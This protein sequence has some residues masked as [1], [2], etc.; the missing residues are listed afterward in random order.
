MPSGAL[1]LTECA[2]TL[3][4][5]PRW[6]HCLTSPHSPT[7]RQVTRASVLSGRP[8]NTDHVLD[9]PRT[10]DHSSHGVREDP[11][12][13]KR[14][15]QRARQAMDRCVAEEHTTDEEDWES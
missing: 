7:G 12:Q 4:D 15:I 11:S 9:R 6:V 10:T 1:T 2:F 8:S 3:T 13:E 14:E 5:W